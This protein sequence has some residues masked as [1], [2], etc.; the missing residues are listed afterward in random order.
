[1]KK[2]KLA[3]IIVITMSVLALP[4]CSNKSAE[5]KPAAATAVKEAKKVVEAS[6]VVKAS[7]VEN[8]VIDMP[9]GTSP[10]I[11]KLDIKNGQK[12]KKGDKLAELDI[13]DYNTLITQKSKAI[14]ADKALRKDM[15]TSNQ[16]KAQDLKIEGEEAELTAL[17]AKAG[18]NYIS[19][20]NI[21]SDMDNAVVTDIGYKQGDIINSQQKVM[22]LEDLNSLVI[23]AD[24]DEEFIKDIKEGSTVTIIP[25]YNP[26]AK[27]TGKVGR[28]YNEAVKQNGDTF[29]N[30]E[31]TMDNNEVK[32]LPNYSV[33]VEI[34]KD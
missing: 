33:D 2:Y 9:I 20:G 19:N 11:L 26:S 21:V 34:S 24:V 10:K 16:K 8:I 7:N 12:V 28:I 32:L 6:G 13:S 22:T 27:I 29:V 4:A 25:K 23:I 31:I 1:M 5:T 18:K 15:P 14:E 17:K 3:V 30:I